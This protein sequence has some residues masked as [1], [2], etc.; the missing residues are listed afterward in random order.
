MLPLLFSAL[1]SLNTWFKIAQAS[2]LMRVVWWCYAV[3]AVGHTA[4]VCVSV[5]VWVR[6]TSG[7]G[8]LSLHCN[9]Q[10][11]NQPLMETRHLIALR[12]W[13]LLVWA[14]MCD[15]APF[16]RWINSLPLIKN[17]CVPCR[18][19]VWMNGNGIRLRSNSPGKD[20]KKWLRSVCKGY[21]TQQWDE[22]AL[23]HA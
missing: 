12:C 21:I 11:A 9:C 8:L 7:G 16:E 10:L 4:S 18:L 13:K 23:L 17:A 19:E 15:F 6:V 22:L 1:F 3:Q 5:C 20:A 14:A 2:L